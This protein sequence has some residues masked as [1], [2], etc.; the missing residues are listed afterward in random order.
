MKNLE[1]L[2]NELCPEGVEFVKFKDCCDYV[3][4]ITY[5]KSKEV[6][7]DNT[8]AW[9]VLRANNI[10][11]SNNHLNFD[12]VKRVSKEVKVKSTQML[13]NGDILICAGSGSKDHIGKVAYIEKNLEYT[14]GGFM[15][16]IRS[17]KIN[18]RFLFHILTG[19]SF[20]QYLSLALNSSTI[21][22]LNSSVMGN[23]EFPLP[24]IEVQ[25]EIVRI[26]DKFTELEAELD[27][28]KRQYEYYRDKLLSFENVGGQ[29]V[30]WK[31][32]SEVGTFIRGNGLQKKDFTEAG[33]GCIHYG[34][35][36]THYGTSATKTITYCSPELATKLRKASKGDVVIATTSENVEDVCKAVAWLG[37]NDVAVSGDAFIYKHNQNPK[38]MAY[39]L[40]TLD[41][42]NYKKK[43]ATGTKVIRLSGDAM[44]NYLAPIPPLAEQE[45]IVS[46]LDRFES[47]TTS[48]TAGLPAEIAARRQQYEHYRDKLLTFKRKSA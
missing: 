26:L 22:N 40:Q 25:T 18:T 12:D 37:D 19:N 46:I 28:R 1:T 11:L 23:F 30:E 35:L 6:F 39:L 20:K 3:R 9:N 8:P 15:A 4:G 7:D 38:Y 16:V 34:Q 36:Y 2:I 24:P 43:K 48:L 13:K 33:V 47:L 17:T 14:F 27:C 42:F 21:N 32:M 10:T 29:N 41:F 44:G 5:N 45:R 31:K